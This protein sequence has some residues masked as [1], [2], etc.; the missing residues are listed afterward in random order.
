[1]N[2]AQQPPTTFAVFI[3]SIS[4]KTEVFKMND[5]KKFFDN[6]K[7]AAYTG[8]AIMLLAAAA[9]VFLPEFKSV[10]LTIAVLAAA[11]MA[12]LFGVAFKQ[13]AKKINSVETVLEKASGCAAVKFD[14]KS[15]TAYISPKFSAVTGIDVASEIIDEID[16]KKLM[17]ELISY[18]CDAGADI[19]MAA[20]PESWIRIST[21]EN[22]DYEFTIIS[23][24]SEYVSCKNIIKSLKYYDSETG[25]LC[26]DTFISQVRSVASSGKGTVGLINLLISGVDKVT[27]FKGTSAADKIISKT[28]AFIKLYENPHN[29]FA[30]R[31]ATNEFCFMLTD[32]YEEGCKKYADK[33]FHGLSEALSTI[34]NSGYIRVYCG[35]AVFDNTEND[36]GEMISAVDYAAFEAKTSGASEPVAFDRTNYVLRA[37]DFKKIQVF[38]TVIYENRMT[39]HFQPV[40]DAKT[41]DIFGY[42]ALM[43]P[44][45]IDGI[46]LTPLEV[47]KIAE[48]QNVLDEIERLT[49]SNAIDF[50]AEN[51]DFF[52]NKRLFINT[53]PNCFITDEEYEK[54]FNK[55][56][57]LFDKIIL[58]IT[59]G[60]QIKPESI[61]L[62]RSRYSSKRALFALDD[63]GSGYA[64]ESTLLSIQPDFI[65][66]DRSL[67]SGIDT[68]LQKQ[69]LVGNMISFAKNHGI[70]TLGEGVE[71]R[72]E[73]ETVITLGVDYVQGYYTSKPNAIILMDV[74]AD[75]RSEILD[76]NLKYSGYNQKIYRM[77]SDSPEDVNVLAAQGYT[78]IIVETPE[79]TLIGDSSHSVRMRICCK[80]NYCGRINI[81]SVNIF[82]L[83]APVLT[84]G[85]NCDVQLHAEGK[86]CFSHEGIRVPES[87]R[88][89]FTGD[90]QLNIDV[91]TDNGIVIGGNRK[92]DFGTVILDADGSLNITAN[93]ESIVAIGGGIGGENSLIEMNKGFVTT[94]IK[95]SSVVGIGAFSGNVNIRLKGGSVDIDSSG[96]H[97]VAAGSRS[98]SVSIECSANISASCSG[99]RCCAVGVLE[100][101]SGRIVMS[102]G[103]YDLNLHVKNG[104]AIGTSAGTVDVSVNDGSY[105]IFCEGNNV[106]GIGD[107]KGLGNVTVSGGTFTIHTAASNELPI[108]SKNGKTVIRGGSITSDSSSPINAVS[109]YGDPLEPKKIETDGKFRKAIVFGGS[110]YTYSAEPMEYENSVTVYL[111]VGYQI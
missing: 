27:S 41:G 5:E 4:N 71:K 47:I 78:D 93:A 3:N 64:N 49:V 11:G 46:K 108:G 43:R 25:L 33:L 107:D 56:G 42:E 51:Q 22:E 77:S 15:E 72:S 65:K 74:P 30:G 36:S 59:E 70:K 103:R 68:D 32:T 35:Y 58:E 50:L 57:E 16:Y 26:R 8:V 106:V 44:Q 18:P 63:Y 82:G 95:G 89:T 110:E 29:A 23:D 101:G 73:L 17:C 91:S 80:D 98:G 104:I 92:Q 105:N 61:E 38:N 85:K 84:L 12:V 100:N 86:N 54:L 13:L 69:N 96:H 9:A 83:E 97:V 1:M 39:Y 81:R 24:V 45:E 66:I 62:M 55:Y 111:P 67:I 109:P 102:K 76:I 20:R 99:D 40:V 48:E 37:Y 10:A 94:E 75:I 60:S 90:G 87:S 6:I 28:A 21:F 31:T 79:A 52:S 19:Y 14:K 53:I 2:E 7:K 88:L 34:D